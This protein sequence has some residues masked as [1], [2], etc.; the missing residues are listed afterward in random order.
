VRATNLQV[1]H[2][3]I[4]GHHRGMNKMYEAIKQHTIG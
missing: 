3:S 4:L 1:T 2:A